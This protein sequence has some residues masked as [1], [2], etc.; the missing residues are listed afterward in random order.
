MAFLGPSF[1][2]PF[3]TF[4]TFRLGFTNLHFD[5]FQRPGL[6]ALNAVSVG[7]WILVSGIM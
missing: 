5:V 3:S 7:Y 2:D 4:L 1:I 6:G